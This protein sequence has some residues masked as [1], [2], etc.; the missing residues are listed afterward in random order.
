MHACASHTNTTD[1]HKLRARKYITR[2]T[3]RV[4]VCSRSRVHVHA[5]VKHVIQVPPYLAEKSPEVQFLR[6]VRLE[7]CNSVTCSQD[8]P[9]R[10]VTPSTYA[11]EQEMSSALVHAKACM[12]VQVYVCC[13]FV[14]GACACVCVARVCVL[15]CGWAYGGDVC[16]P[17]H[18]NQQS[19]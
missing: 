1:A 11:P 12:L 5:L 15:V 9:F 6:G 7:I 19:N 2:S 13:M 16:L 8:Q 10:R 18:Q 14:H 3:Q 4:C 17:H